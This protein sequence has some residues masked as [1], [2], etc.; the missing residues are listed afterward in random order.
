MISS[1]LFSGAGDKFGRKPIALAGSV[2]V[3]L[4]GLLCAATNKFWQLVFLRS[5]VGVFMGIA[6]GPSTAF[7]GKQ[8]ISNKVLDV[9][10]NL[11]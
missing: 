3:T 9:D 4:V 6:M 8:K 5:L 7:N 1:F 11:T 10:L 2:G